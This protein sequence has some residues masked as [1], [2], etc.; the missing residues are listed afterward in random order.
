M[1]DVKHREKKKCILLKLLLL[2]VKFV[3]KNIKYYDNETIIIIRV[4]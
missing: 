1:N 2:L 3:L 4:K